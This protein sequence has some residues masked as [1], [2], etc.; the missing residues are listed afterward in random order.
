MQ[1]KN[2]VSKGY[3]SVNFFDN[4]GG[5]VLVLG[6]LMSLIF[7]IVILKMLLKIARRV[8]SK[9]PKMFFLT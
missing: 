8:F 7:M 6:G 4:L 9:S 2:L 3:T 5:F 1:D